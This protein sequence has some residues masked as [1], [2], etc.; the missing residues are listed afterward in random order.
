MTTTEHILAIVD[1]AEGGE[2]TL[3]IARDVVS[4]GGRATI[5]VLS[6][7]LLTGYVRAFAA[8]ENLDVN[9]ASAIY[10]DRLT[11]GY[12]ARVGKNGTSVT[13]DEHDHGLQV[14][15]DAA[16]AG[17]TT[18]AIPQRLLGDRRWRATV[19]HSRLP[20]VVTPPRAA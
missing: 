10:N 5:V 6:D 7:A 2:A 3:D 1:A 20:V 18:V 12:T 8:S 4:R 16:D 9:V 14:V 17:A 13:I 11:S 15:A 19:R